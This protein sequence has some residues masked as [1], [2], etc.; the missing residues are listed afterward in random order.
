MNNSGPEVDEDRW[1]AWVDKGE[2]RDKATD[3]KLKIF[4]GAILTV[5]AAGVGFYILAM[6]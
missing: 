1:R 4:V 6:R 3:R 5:L 2:Q